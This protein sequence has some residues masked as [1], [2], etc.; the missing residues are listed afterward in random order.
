MCNCM[1]TEVMTTKKGVIV[2]YLCM[3]ITASA[4]LY[5]LFCYCIF[6]KSVYI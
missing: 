3:F 2:H 6:I 4:I 5:N 1:N